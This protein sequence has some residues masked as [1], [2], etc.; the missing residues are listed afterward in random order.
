V[1][2]QVGIDGATG[3]LVV[4]GQKFF[5]IGLSNPP[6]PDSKTPAGRNGLE[7]VHANGVNVVRTGIADWSMAHADA[8]ISKQEDFHK[9]IRDSGL[10]HWLWLGGVPDLPG[11]GGPAADS[12]G[13]LTKLVTAFRSDP[14]LLAYKGID[15][16]Q[17]AGVAHEGLVAAYT[18]LKQV[19]PDHPVVLIQ[20]PRGSAADLAPYRPAFDITGADIF[21]I[22]YP[23]GQQSDIPNKDVNVVGDVTR[24]M[25]DAAGGKP[26]WMTLQIA[27]SGVAPT[28]SHPEIVPRFPSLLQERFMAY[29]A[30]VNGARGLTFFGGHMR[31]VMIPADAASG[32]NWTFWRRVLRPVVSELSSPDVAPALVAPAVKP[33]VKAAPASVMELVTRRAGNFLYV[34]A[35]RI[36]GPASQIQFTG[37][38]KRNNGSALASGEVLAEYVQSPP[39][40]PVTGEQALRRVTVT[41][42]KFKDW[43]ATYDAHVYRF[44]L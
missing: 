26:I 34:I 16:P 5:P 19:D 42:G 44:A 6:P 43:F 4:D 8:Q 10:L 41:N 24:R 23:P 22:A 39:P 40:P 29:E 32:W 12:E 3:S 11:P 15:E 1:S 38:P 21:P 9:A 2:P 25:R 20:A 27:W 17:H 14:A 31:Q 35:V 7:E 28:K 13:L 36:A 33:G 37:L 18:K 30:I